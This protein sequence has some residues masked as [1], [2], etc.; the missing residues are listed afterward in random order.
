MTPTRCLI[1]TTRLSDGRYRHVSRCGVV[2]ET[3][4]P[5]L[6]RNCDLG[7]CRQWVQEHPV[8][9]F[10][11]LPGSMLLWMLRELGLTEKPGCGCKTKARQM[12]EWG[13]DGCRLHH[14]EI[15][16]WLRRNQR[17]WTTAEKLAAACKAVKTGLAIRL[18][19][20]DPLGSLVDES[21]RLASLAEH[22]N[23]PP[24]S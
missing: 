6:I 14:E 21:I 19:P 17:K 7:L 2:R 3:T 24:A 8:E 9:A 1:V 15:V 5:R 20:W 13:V 12:N 11:G 10:A 22:N 18:K 23:A 4:Q 16:G